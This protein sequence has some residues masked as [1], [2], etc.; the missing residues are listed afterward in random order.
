MLPTDQTKNKKKQRNAR[1]HL[2]NHRERLT[3]QMA[4]SYRVKDFH[5]NKSSTISKRTAHPSGRDDADTYRRCNPRA[6]WT[7]IFGPQYM[8]EED[9]VHV[10]TRRIIHEGLA[11][12]SVSKEAFMQEEP[13]TDG[14]VTLATSRPQT[15]WKSHCHISQR[16]PTTSQR[17]SII[18]TG[19]KAYFENRARSRCVILSNRQQRDRPLKYD[20][21][22]CLGE[23]RK[24][25]EHLETAKLF[26]AKT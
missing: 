14:E 11:H 9:T 24:M 8:T 3:C 1:H 6:Q 15:R 23:K 18:H 20:A 19:R 7:S 17:W 16:L 25:K 10:E 26:G 12:N 5:T 13:A 4:E 2:A 22:I 21:I